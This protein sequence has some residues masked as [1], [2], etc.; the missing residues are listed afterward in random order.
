MLKPIYSDQE[1]VEK[2]NNY[3]NTEITYVLNNEVELKIKQSI[4]KWLGSKNLI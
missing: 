1:Y 2:I 3:E 4:D